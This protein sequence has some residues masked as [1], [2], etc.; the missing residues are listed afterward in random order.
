MKLALPMLGDSFD[1]FRFSAP[2]GP[3][4]TAPVVK[5]DA[6]GDGKLTVADAVTLQNW[7]MGKSNAVI[8]DT[9]TVDICADGQ[10]NIFDFIKLKE[11]IAELISKQPTDKK[12]GYNGEYMNNEWVAY[13]EGVNGEWI[14]TE[15]GS[16]AWLWYD[17]IEKIPGQNGEYVNGE[18]VSYKAGQ[19]GDWIETEDGSNMWVWYE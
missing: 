7:L 4:S 5:G 9:N 17:N 12:T 6:N 11:M 8:S 14:E 16:F 19:N 18:W 3:N 2:S 13:E 15:D 10:V 1:S